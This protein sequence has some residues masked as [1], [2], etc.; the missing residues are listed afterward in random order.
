MQRMLDDCYFNQRLYSNKERLHKLKLIYLDKYIKLVEEL[1][2]KI[3]YLD[4]NVI[5]ISRGK[6]KNRIRL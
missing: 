3:D 2:K 6:I 1:N 4:P 5:K